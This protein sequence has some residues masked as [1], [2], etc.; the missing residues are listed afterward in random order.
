M[1]GAE[2][3]GMEGISVNKKRN[4]SPFLKKSST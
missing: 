1:D 2:Y 3:N 4:L